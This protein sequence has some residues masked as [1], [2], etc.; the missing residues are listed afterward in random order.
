MAQAHTLRP[1]DA[2]MS[3]SVSNCAREK[4]HCVGDSTI[5]GVT[6]GDSLAAPSSTALS[7]W[8]A[9]CSSLRRNRASRGASAEA[10]ASCCAWNAADDN[11]CFPLT[12]RC[13]LHLRQGQFDV[14]R[15]QSRSRQAGACLLV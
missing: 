14:S 7:S 9:N 12:L 5:S 4:M 13:R 2:T 3:S 10:R 15:G 6:A 8:R 11:G 1:M